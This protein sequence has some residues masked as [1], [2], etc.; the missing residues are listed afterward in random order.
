MREMTPSKKSLAPLY[1][2]CSLA[3]MFSCSINHNDVEISSVVIAPVNN[4]TMTFIRR[5]SASVKLNRFT[6]N[7]LT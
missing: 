7:D 4:Y 5:T 6:I 3:F 1:P 2:C